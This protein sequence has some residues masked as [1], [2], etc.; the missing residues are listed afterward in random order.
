MKNYIS[1][2][3]ISIMARP[4][5]VCRI[6]KDVDAVKDIFEEMLDMVKGAGYKYV[7]I[8]SLEVDTM[9]ANYI[10]SQLQNRGL[11]V[12]E[13]IHF[14]EFAKGR[15]GRE[16]RI[17]KGKNAV[18]VAKQFNTEIL[19]L[20]PGYCEE[21]Q[22]LSPRQIRNNMKTEFVAIGNFAKDKGLTTVIEDTPDLRLRMCRAEDVKEVLNDTDIKLVYDSGNMILEG[23][24]PLEY[25][26]SFRGK[27]G[28]VHLKDIAVAQKPLFMGEYAIDG[29]PYQCVPTGKGIV[30][31]DRVI[32]FLK[33]MGYE[34]GVTIEF[35]Y[36][37]Q[38]S[39]SE[40]LQDSLRYVERY[41]AE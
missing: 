11:N 12:G 16:E 26:S 6:D 14:D 22:E 36:D 23:E 40:S 38:K 19:M 33:N 30:G 10:F 8:T 21:I 18:W 2:M 31:I 20:V 34:G 9:G 17:E 35:A 28:Y 37:S 29:T 32:E 13:Y 15:E 1:I 7:D 41:F 27:I 3:T 4:C 39:Y 25:L 5:Y 24:N